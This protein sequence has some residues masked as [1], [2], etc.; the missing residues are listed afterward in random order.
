MF[1]LLLALVPW[2]IDEVIELNVSPQILRYNCPLTECKEKSGSVTFS[3]SLDLFR[4]TGSGDSHPSVILFYLATFL[5][6]G[7]SAEGVHASKAYAWKAGCMHGRYVQSECA[8]AWR[9]GAK[10]MCNPSLIRIFGSTTMDLLIFLT[11][12]GMDL[13]TDVS[14]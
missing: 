1:F 4:W 8:Q 7:A 3:A 6:P 11:A 9:T 10:N 13:S 14:L 12:L 2:P 5:S